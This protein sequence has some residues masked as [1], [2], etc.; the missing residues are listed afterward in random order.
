M[1]L[2]LAVA[3]GKIGRRLKADFASSSNPPI[4]AISNL[5]SKYD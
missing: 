1:E 3:F 5:L 4:Q 2:S